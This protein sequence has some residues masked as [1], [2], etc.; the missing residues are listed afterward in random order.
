MQESGGLRQGC[1]ILL[2]INDTQYRI[3]KFLVSRITISIIS[4]EHDRT[5]A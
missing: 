2:K 5:L 4:L 1:K 3:L